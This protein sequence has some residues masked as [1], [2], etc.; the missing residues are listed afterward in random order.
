MDDLAFDMNFDAETAEKIRQISAVKNACVEKEDYEQAKAL[1]AVET[2]PRPLE[3]SLKK[4]RQR[5]LRPCGG[6]YDAAKALKDEISRMRMGVDSRLSRIPAFSMYQEG[7]DS[8]QKGSAAAV[9]AAGQPQ[10]APLEALKEQQKQQQQFAY[11]VPTN[12]LGGVPNGFQASRAGAKPAEESHAEREARLAREQVQQM[13]EQMKAMKRDMEVRMQSSIEKEDRGMREN[14][15]KERAI[16]Q[17]QMEQ[18][19]QQMQQQMQMQCRQPSKH[20]NKK[21]SGCIH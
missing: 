21:S 13:Q 3:Y 9:T 15:E 7:V 12:N 6:D 4:W 10:N 5:K 8:Q 11:D 2:Q 17:R 18:M 20:V 16:L 14:L 1:K 19:Q